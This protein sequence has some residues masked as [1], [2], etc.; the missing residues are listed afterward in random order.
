MNRKV[1]LSLILVNLIGVVLILIGLLSNPEI[2]ADALG[3]TPEVERTIFYLFGGGLLLV[4]NSIT[5]LVIRRNHQ[6]KIKEIN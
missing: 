2:A 4:G 5:A 1:I 3:I 6:I